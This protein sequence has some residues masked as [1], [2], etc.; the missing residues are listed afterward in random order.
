M[1]DVA[2]HNL[3][4]SIFNLTNGTE[5]NQ[6]AATLTLSKD[7]KTLT[8]HIYKNYKVDR[9]YYKV[10][11]TPKGQTQETS[12]NIEIVKAGLGV[13]WQE[14]DADM[15]KG[16]PNRAVTKTE[17][18]FQIDLTKVEPG[19]D[20]IVE[21]YNSK[22]ELQ[23]GETSS[24]TFDRLT[25]SAERYNNLA[26]IDSTDNLSLLTLKKS[27]YRPY[28]DVFTNDYLMK[29]KAADAQ[30]DINQIYRDPRSLPASETEFKKNTEKIQGFTKYDGGSIR[31]LYV[32]E[33]GDK[34]IAKADAESNIYDKDGNI[35][36]DVTKKVTINNK[37]Y[38]VFPYDVYLKAFSPSRSTS[39]VE[40]Q[41]FELK[42]DMRLLFNTSDGSSIPTDWMEQRVKT[43]VLFD[44]TEGSFAENKK[45]DVRIVPDNVKFYD[46]DGYKAN[47]F[48]GANV[49][50]GLARLVSN[51]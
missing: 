1:Q 40:G 23:K 14:T 44:A 43:R 8:T 28:Q 13:K 6:G 10:R 21:S 29:E 26:W 39:P 19:T 38:T 45:Q 35:T 49:A 16:L 17:G 2:D 4:V 3:P 51:S 46:E 15:I 48:K 12:F 32:D 50:E 5:E 47:G 33:N 25:K 24:M 9:G 34:F 11:Y 20:V 31:L 27:A 36:K 41:T 42:K 18:N 7:R 22:G 30:H 37:E